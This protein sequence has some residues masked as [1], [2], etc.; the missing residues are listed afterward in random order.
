MSGHARAERSNGWVKSSPEQ[1]AQFAQEHRDAVAR[2]APEVQAAF[3]SWAAAGYAG[4]VFD[5]LKRR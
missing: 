3:A 4:S 1:E 2:A 5:Y